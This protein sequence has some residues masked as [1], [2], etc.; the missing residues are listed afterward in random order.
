[1][2]NIWNQKSQ[3]SPT[4]RALRVALI[5]EP[6]R[7]AYVLERIED[8]VDVVAELGSG[9]NIGHLASIHPDVVLLDC[10]AQNVNPLVTLPRLAALSGSP[11][12]VALTDSSQTSK[13][14]ERALL[15]LGADATIDI[16]DASEFDRAMKRAEIRTEVDP[17]PVA[18]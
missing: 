12:I 16:R 6:D 1:M 15:D 9:R 13:V 8:H 4:S 17:S 2:L 3:T 18:A 10:G 14:Q 7:R 11:Y 5:G